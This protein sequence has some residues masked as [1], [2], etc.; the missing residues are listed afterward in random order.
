MVGLV[1]SSVSYWKDEF[2]G[3]TLGVSLACVLQQIIQSPN[4]N[5]EVLFEKPSK[6]L[7]PANIDN[8]IVQITCGGSCGTGILIDKQ[9]GLIVTT[10]HTVRSVSV[11]FR[12][13]LAQ[14]IKHITATSLNMVLY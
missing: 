13:A 12:H 2:C 11:K 6:D 10:S 8:S 1:L 14:I 3:F 4:P 9:N 5:D 7:Q